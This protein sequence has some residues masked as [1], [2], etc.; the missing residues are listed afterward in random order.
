MRF[1]LTELHVRPLLVEHPDALANLALVCHSTIQ[2]D[3]F[4]G[5]YRSM[6]ED[7]GNVL[8][9]LRVAAEPAAD[10]LDDCERVPK[11]MNCDCH[12]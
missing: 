8:A 7:G 3:V 4:G 1:R 10:V 11:R 6:S 5:L 2:I 12:T 9:R